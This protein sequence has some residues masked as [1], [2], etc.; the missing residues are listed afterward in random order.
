[1]KKGLSVS[2]FLLCSGLVWS[3]L[4]PNIS[5]AVEVITLRSGQTGGVPGVP[6]SLDDIVRFNPGGNPAAA[7]VLG[8]PFTPAYDAATNAGA[9]AKVIAPVFAWMGG[10]TAPLSDP[11]ARW[12]NFEEDPSSGF[13]IAAG[14]ALYSVPFF[15][16]SAAIGNATLVVEGG[17]DDW[18][19]D[20]L[21]GGPN[22]DGLY[23]N[24][25]P[26]GLSTLGAG[27]FNFATPTTHAVNIT[28]NVFPGQNYL[29]FY[30]RDGGAGVSGLIFS[31]TITVVPEP[32]TLGLTA[33][34]LLF[35][36]PRRRLI[37]SC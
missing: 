26:S 33:I 37:R 21:G 28:A 22:P 29:Y 9:K 25:V 31:A 35:T 2:F 14:S 12:I 4:L 24:G 36:L 32:T 34:G 6:G 15:I 10:A 18:L 5:S 17:V 13:G 8:S 3:C 1:M 7:P 23:V 30:Q 20:A 19:G 11:L 16:N 27:D